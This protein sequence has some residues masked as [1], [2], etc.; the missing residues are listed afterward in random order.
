MAHHKAAIKSIKSDKERQERNN[1]ERKS[2]RTAIK[3]VKQALNREQAEKA[4]EIAISKLDKAARKGHIHKNNA[5]RNKSRL[6]KRVRS[7]Q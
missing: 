7:L 2:L 6:I 1:V 5:A 3:H 4:L